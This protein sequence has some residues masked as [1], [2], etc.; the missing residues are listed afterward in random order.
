MFLISDGSCT[1]MMMVSNVQGTINDENMVSV[2]WEWPQ[3]AELNF[4][5]VFAVEEDIPLEEILRKNIPGTVYEDTFGLRHTM[6]LEKQSVIIKIYP[7]RKVSGKDYELINQ[8]RNNCSDIFYKKVNLSYHVDYKSSFLSPVKTAILQV[9]G[10]HELNEGCLVY[11]CVGE[12]RGGIRYPI[13]VNKFGRQG[14]L[15]IHL[16]RKEE[17]VLELTEKQKRY[18]TLI[19]S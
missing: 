19:R 4:C 13:D 7:A 2:T 11:R 16:S 17:I 9:Y 12:A 10:I 18:I 14:S 5:V 8:V 6:E 1:D 3:I 15:E